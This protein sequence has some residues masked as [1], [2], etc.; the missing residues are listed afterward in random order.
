MAR[1]RAS[2]T[3][4]KSSD[5]AHGPSRGLDRLKLLLIDDHPLFRE[6]LCYLL[7]GLAENIEIV[8][9]ENF[10]QARKLAPK[11]RNFD[12][13]LA[14]HLM[15]NADG[16]AALRELQEEMPETPIVVVSLLED[17][18]DV[19]RALKCGA[20]GY[21][22]KSSSSEIMLNAL[23]LV[24]AGGLYLPPALLDTNDAKGTPGRG[25]S[26]R[27]PAEPLTGR[28][29]A[30]TA[31]QRDVLSHLATGQSNRGIAEALGLAE[32]TVKVHVTAILKALGVRN[33]TQAVLAVTSGGAPGG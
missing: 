19:I 16:Y 7:R 4:E 29:G 20:K 32:G 23:R 31:R 30:L 14:D 21:I 26:E 27:R 9:V 2:A 28:I 1:I 24:L 15:P 10:E 5:P 3:Q 8:E 12:L 33:R 17:R 22:P 6:G 25:L 18:A 13:V 11:E